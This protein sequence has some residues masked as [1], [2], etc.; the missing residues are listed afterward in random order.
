ML[1][2]LVLT[3]F[4]LTVLA[5]QYVTMSETLSG[6]VVVRF[7]FISVAVCYIVSNFKYLKIYSTFLSCVL[8]WIVF[9]PLVFLST[10][11]QDIP[12]L[13]SFAKL[14]DFLQWEVVFLFFFIVA[15][16]E[17][18]D[19]QVYVYSILIFAL[20][21]VMFYFLYYHFQQFL[22]ERAVELGARQGVIQSYFLLCM[23][24]LLV[25]LNYEKKVMYLFWGVTFVVLEMS[26]KRTGFTA[27]LLSLFVFLFF[28]FRKRKMLFFILMLVAVSSLYYSYET[29]VVDTSTSEKTYES[30]FLRFQEGTLESNGAVRSEYRRIAWNFFLDTPIHRKI[31]GYGVDGYTLFGITH[32]STHNDYL[33]ILTNYGL[34]YFVLFLWLLG[35]LFNSF[36]KS[37]SQ[38]DRC[39]MMMSIV[40]LLLV[41]MFSHLLTRPEGFLF[42]CAYWGYSLGKSNPVDSPELSDQPTAVL[43]S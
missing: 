24:P 37:S 14:I 40:I 20:S 4:T 28:K 35:C 12:V 8:S 22:S 23:L 5:R 10:F 29:F 27:C 36:F 18:K 21:V 26:M 13:D 2:Y 16:K 33:E 17:K 38:K 41:S 43:A 3:L 6:T 42:L 34:I 19:L 25:Y 11:I 30:F 1:F 15:R 7:A 39:A 31:C 32:T 9:L